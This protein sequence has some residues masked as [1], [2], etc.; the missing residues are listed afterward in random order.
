MIIADFCILCIGQITCSICHDV[1]PLEVQC[2]NRNIFRE[3]FFSAYNCQQIDKEKGWFYLF[4]PDTESYKVSF[5][6]LMHGD[7][8]TVFPEWQSTIRKLLLYYLLKS[9]NK[10][11]AVLIRAQGYSANVVHQAYSLDE[12]M[13]DICSG[14]IRLNEIYYIGTQYSKKVIRFAKYCDSNQA[15]LL[16]AYN[17]H[18]IAYEGQTLTSETSATGTVVSGNPVSYYNGTRWNFTRE[19]SRRLASASGKGRNV[20]F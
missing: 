1:S 16:T 7:Y 18:A 5:F 3:A 10:T 15:D 6:D 8:I 19:G 14:Q 2:I 11:V 20:N 9:P 17:G 12:F 13:D 4:W